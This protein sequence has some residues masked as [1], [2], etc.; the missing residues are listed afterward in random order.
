MI[1]LNYQALGGT[2]TAISISR[3]NDLELDTD[4][5]ETMHFVLVCE[6]VCHENEPHIAH[7]QPHTAH[8]RMK[9]TVHDVCF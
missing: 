6:A 3:E 8:M 4:N 2:C 9:L 5:Y 7:T 1:T